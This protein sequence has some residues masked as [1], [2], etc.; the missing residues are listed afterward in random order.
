[1]E[2]PK[3]IRNFSII[4]HIDHGKSTLGDRLLDMTGTIA[5]NKLTPQFLDSMDLEKEKG[6]TIKMKPV[7]MK[8][9]PKNSDIEYN[10]NLIDTPGHVDFSY[11]VSRCMAAVE[12]AILLVDATKGIQAQTLSNLEMARKEGITI[13]PV[14]NKIDL[15]QAR[16]EE[17][18]KE[19]ASLLGIFEEDVI[20]ISAKTGENVE[21]LL[22]KVIA[23]VPAPELAPEKPFRAVIFDSKF[24]AF[25]GVLA[26]VRVVDGSIK[27][28]DKFFLYATKARGEVKELGF[29]KPNLVP[30]EELNSGEI[31]Y[32]ATGI[33]ELEKI[34]I[35]DTIARDYGPDEVAITVEPLPGYQQ[36]NPKVFV[37]I[38]PE[39]QADFELLRIALSK[40]KLSDSALFFQPQTY[41]V[42]GRGF[43][44]GFLGTLH[45][46][47]TIERLKR[48]F[49]LS[50]VIGAPQ[51]CYKV[52]EFNGKESLIFSP[53]EFPETPKTVLEPWAEIKIIT[54]TQYLGNIYDL[55]KSFEGEHLDSVS[56][57]GEKFLLTYNIPMRNLIGSFYERL[58]NTS[59]GFASLS[60]KEIGFR[61]GELAK[62]EIL[63]SGKKEEALSRI[64]PK[65]KAHFEGKRMVEMLEDVLPP[66]MFAVSIQACSMGRIVARADKSAKRR[67]V[68]AP[69]Y[70]GDYTRKKKLLEQQKKGKEKLKARGQMRIPPEVFVKIFTSSN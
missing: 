11:E 53:S 9:R 14:V 46:E 10:L 70:G 40:L 49:N 7:S 21:F 60:Y 31:G 24:D 25:L 32:I 8:Y 52:I 5:K 66:Q 67:D 22:E 23:N 20:P 6:I 69:L 50:L 37:F 34:S 55:L 16:V 43:L 13:I 64:V 2:S 51:V 26:Y 19:L 18:K 56:F 41:Q 59:Q 29:F 3:Q 38:C 27:K 54:P 15:P 68:I 57:L 65:D 39:N 30:A 63:I 44:C 58:L 33:K 36:A 35:G 4:S 17:T 12:G 45:G 1:M 62:M 47:I 61:P 48:E 28:Y 42:L